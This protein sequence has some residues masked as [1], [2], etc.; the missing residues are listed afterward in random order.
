MARLAAEPWEERD[1]C[2]V[3]RAFAMPLAARLDD[4]AGLRVAASP[5]ALDALD[6]ATAAGTLAA[7]P[8]L[9][10]VAEADPGPAAVV[11]LRPSG[12]EALLP[13]DARRQF[14]LFVKMMTANIEWALVTARSDGGLVRL[15]LQLTLVQED[16]TE[17]LLRTAGGFVMRQARQAEAVRCM[18]NLRQLG[19]ALTA[20]GAD[21][22]DRLPDDLA[23]LTP[24]YLAQPLACPNGPYLYLGKGVS[25]KGTELHQRMVACCPAAHPAGNRNLLFL[26]GHVQAAPETRAVQEIEKAR[27]VPAQ[28]LEKQPGLRWKHADPYDADAAWLAFDWGVAR[29]AGGRA[30]EFRNLMGEEQARPT[31]ITFTKDGVWVGTERGLFVWDRQK[32]FW[33]RMAVGGGLLSPHVESLKADG[34]RIEVVIRADGGV[35]RHVFNLDARAWAK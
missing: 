33:A 14:G 2:V 4:K 25:L 21:H 12:I 29:V 20:W 30:D 9:K 34:G 23:G 18:S 13:E 11:W 27:R 31:A 15:R 3:T 10:G 35:E 7:L 19:L 26:D 28:A 32:R 16:T 5:D 8:G 6:R 22:G 17:A 1:G 24:N